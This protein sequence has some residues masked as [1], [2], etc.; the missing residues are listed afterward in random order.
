MTSLR[1]FDRPR[2][3]EILNG[4]NSATLHLIHFAFGSKVWVKFWCWWMEWCYS[5]PGCTKFKLVASGHFK[6]FKWRYL[7]SRSSDPFR[8]HMATILCSQTLTILHC[9]HMW[10]E[11]GDL[12]W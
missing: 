4:H 5:S 6:N 10:Q 9:W 12:L 3:M 11:F 1:L 8:A 7:C 2:T